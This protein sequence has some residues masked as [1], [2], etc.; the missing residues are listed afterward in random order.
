MNVT[1]FSSDYSDPAFVKSRRAQRAFPPSWD[2]Q[3]SAHRLLK[4]MLGLDVPIIWRASDLPTFVFIWFSN[5]SLVNKPCT[6]PGV[7]TSEGNPVVLWLTASILKAYKME[8][9]KPASLWPRISGSMSLA[10]VSQ[11]TVCT[12]LLGEVDRML[13]CRWT[14]KPVKSPAPCVIHSTSTSVLWRL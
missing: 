8:G 7:L 9:S 12:D 11:G 14:M 6:I 13:A 2:W 4:G 5:I 3:P 10:T 1:I